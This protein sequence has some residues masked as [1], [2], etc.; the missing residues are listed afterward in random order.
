MKTPEKQESLEI[1]DV[2]ISNE[3]KKKSYKVLY[4]LV[5]KRKTFKIVGFKKKN[6]YIN[7]KKEM[8]IYVFCF[9]T[10]YIPNVIFE[11][12]MNLFTRRLFDMNDHEI[13]TTN[14]STLGSLSAKI[15]F[16]QG[17]E[18]QPSLI[19]CKIIDYNEKK[20]IEVDAY[21]FKIIQNKYF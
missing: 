19:P 3:A 10:D 17:F 6:I 11:L 15:A 5:K 1:I 20:K 13:E 21:V 14:L 16:E 18:I 12:P 4:E 2:L 7:D 9:T 8:T